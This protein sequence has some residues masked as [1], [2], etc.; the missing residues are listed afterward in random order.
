[1]SSSSVNNLSPLGQGISTLAEMPMASRSLAGG[2]L[3]GFTLG[4]AALRPSAFQSRSLLDRGGGEIE[5]LTLEF[6]RSKDPEILYTLLKRF[7]EKAKRE[8]VLKEY[9]LNKI[10]SYAGMIGQLPLRDTLPHIF[11][12]IANAYAQ[13][14]EFF[15]SVSQGDLEKAI[16]FRKDIEEYHLEFN[17]MQ[18][19]LRGENLLILSS[20][21]LEAAS[22]FPTAVEDVISY[23]NH[24]EEAILSGV[25]FFL[26]NTVLRACCLLHLSEALSKRN[27]EAR[28]GV[29]SDRES[30]AHYSAIAREIF[31]LQKDHLTPLQTLYWARFITFDIEPF[32]KD[33]S[34]FDTIKYCLVFVESLY[35]KTFD[36]SSSQGAK[37]FQETALKRCSNFH[38]FNSLIYQRNTKERLV[39]PS[40]LDQMI[41]FGDHLEELFSREIPFLLPIRSLRE[42]NLMHLNW[43]H[44]QRLE[45]GFLSNSS[46]DSII[47]NGQK[48]EALF[49]RK[50]NPSLLDFLIRAANLTYMGCT[51]LN[52]NGLVKEL[53]NEIAIGH[54]ETARRLFLYVNQQQELMGNHLGF[55]RATLLEFLRG[56]IGLSEAL[57]LKGDPS[58]LSA[59]ISYRTQ[60]KDILA[61]LGNM[62]EYESRIQSWNILILSHLLFY[63]SNLYL[64]ENPVLPE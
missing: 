21:L 39:N 42:Q 24:A 12:V 13:R 59:I 19:P 5:R 54:L 57:E 44:S 14:Y 47:Y 62:S 36:F 35:F 32:A 27:L 51:M 25:D 30:I 38:A 1:V 18:S 37:L 23:V 52:K 45:C 58:N 60:A 63:Q 4:P 33:P 15:C 17:Y 55:K 20:H 22:F 16:Q 56:L 64:G 34:A 8:L 31:I 49:L 26:G 7:E 10:I 53:N 29:R 11:A 50:E 41:L 40:D 9:Y 2:V 46:F 48:A 28:E 6:E 61:N 3:D 43:A